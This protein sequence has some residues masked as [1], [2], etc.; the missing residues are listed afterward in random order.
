M[1][2]QKQEQQ[3]MMILSTYLSVQIIQVDIFAS[4]CRWHHSLSQS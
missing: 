3:Q 1:Q 4:W 2:I